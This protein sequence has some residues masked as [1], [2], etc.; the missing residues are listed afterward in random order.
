MPHGDWLK[1]EF[2]HPS[3]AT[4]ELMTVIYLMQLRAQTW[5]WEAPKK[6]G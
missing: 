3:L 6:K 2:P 5:I 4:G 1:P